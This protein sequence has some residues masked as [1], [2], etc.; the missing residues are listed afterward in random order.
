MN[1]FSF[2]TQNAH[3]RMLTSLSFLL[4]LLAPNV[5]VRPAVIVVSTTIQ[6]AVD[7]ANPGDT[8]RVPPGIYRE[9]VLVNKNNIT[10]KGQSGAILDG[11]GL[12]GN[13]GITV[14]ALSP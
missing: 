11:S 4:I 12:S 2:K 13:S 9:N 8:V 10:I 5:P 7:A 3:S 6:A 1:S 14:R